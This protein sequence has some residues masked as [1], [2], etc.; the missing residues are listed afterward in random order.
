MNVLYIKAR[1]I[2]RKLGLTSLLFKL[3]P[4]RDYEEK[5]KQAILAALRTDDVVWDVGANLGF[6]TEIFAE[7]VGSTGQVIAFEPTPK[8]HSALS[9]RTARYPWVRSEQIALGDFDGSSQFVVGDYDRT[10]HL[11]R[12]GDE[13]KKADSVDVRVMRGDSYLANSEKV[14]NLLKID[15]EGF[16]EEVLKGMEGLLALPELRAVFLEV[17]FRELEQRGR[18]MAP[19]RIENLLR[20]KGLVPKWVDLSH[21]AATRVNA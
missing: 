21:I 10:N 4:R 2:A 8:T 7:N 18:A 17:H 9:Q 12:V 11:Q 6:Y 15:V 1:T 19:V 14:P 20:S 3:A 16:E 13:A 5:F